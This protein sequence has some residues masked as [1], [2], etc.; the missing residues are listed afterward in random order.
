MSILPFRFGTAVSVA[1]V[2]SL[3]GATAASAESGHLVQPG[4]TLSGIAAAHGVSLAAIFAANGM[5]WNTVIYP[6][7]VIKLDA[8]RP[9][10]AP[11][12]GTYTV[13]RGDTLSWI[14]LAHSVDLV[15]VFELNGMDWNTVI[16]PGQVIS[17]PASSASERAALR[18]VAAAPTAPRTA[19]PTAPRTAA[20]SPSSA[21]PTPKPAAPKPAATSQVSS[22]TAPGRATAAHTEPQA[23]SVT[24]T[25][26]VQSLV[27]DE[28]RSM[29]VDPSLALAIAYKES[30]FRPYVT[31]SAG[32]IGPMQ[33]MP[34][35]QAW[36]SS[37]AGWPLNLNDV[38][39]NID[40][41]VAIIRYLV[42]TSPSLDI[43][44]GSYFQGQYSVLYYGMYDSTKAY[45]EDVL[46][47]QATFR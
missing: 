47:L 8:A 22:G 5:G 4:D 27:R 13:R 34:A 1:V 43:A 42:A 31:S 44:I 37:L 11:G 6:G 26:Q 32:A 35:N 10:G 33:I 20:P 38:R 29:G 45:V 19:A 40:A 15:T 30:S 12:A 36:A 9:A 7:Q 24:T 14:A 3:L 18:P 2:T 17:L 46:R 23:P 16:Y 39:D 41:G 21:T 25:D 28:A